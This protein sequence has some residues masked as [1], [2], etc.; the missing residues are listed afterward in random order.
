MG[1]L[2]P[3]AA[4]FSPVL[5]LPQPGFAGLGTDLKERALGAPEF[6]PQ[7]DADGIR[8][9]SLLDNSPLGLVIDFLPA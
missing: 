2:S 9:N 4:R 8:N 5:L 1:V 6:V 7:K 3:P